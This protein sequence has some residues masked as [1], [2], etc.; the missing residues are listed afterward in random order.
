[1][2]STSASNSTKARPVT[3]SSSLRSLN[4]PIYKLNRPMT[5]K[6][7]IFNSQEVKSNKEETKLDIELDTE[8]EASTNLS[9]FSINSERTLPKMKKY[10]MFNYRSYFER[11]LNRKAVVKIPSNLLPK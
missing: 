8:S 11:Y 10:N 6:S 2:A 4:K 7:S 3:A 1:M 5:S 9:L